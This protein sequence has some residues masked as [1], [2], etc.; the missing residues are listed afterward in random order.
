VERAHQDANLSCCASILGHYW[1]WTAQGC[2]GWPIPSFGAYFVLRIY[3]YDM[4]LENDGV[5][6]P[7]IVRVTREQ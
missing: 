4:R 7:L 6:M 1:H 5:A 2:V 3:S